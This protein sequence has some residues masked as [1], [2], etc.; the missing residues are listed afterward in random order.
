MAPAV[1]TMFQLLEGVAVR[2]IRL[3]TRA[4]TGSAITIVCT[5]ALASAQVPLCTS[6][7]PFNPCVPG[8][9]PKATECNVEFA[10]TPV[11]PLTASKMPRNKLICYEG[12][13]RCDADPDLGNGSC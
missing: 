11:P 5:V 8:G 10:V 9:G 7:A 13:P 4:V 6:V 3:A 1:P 2:T 12:D